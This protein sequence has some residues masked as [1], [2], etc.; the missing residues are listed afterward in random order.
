MDKKLRCIKYICFF[1]IKTPKKVKMYYNC[2]IPYDILI[3]HYYLI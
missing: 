1:T 2:P 3:W